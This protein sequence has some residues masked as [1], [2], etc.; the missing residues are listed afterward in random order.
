MAAFTSLALINELCADFVP[1]PPCQLALARPALR[2]EDGE[3]AGNVEMFGDDLYTTRRNV[4]DGAVTRQRTRPELDFGEAPAYAAFALAS[5]CK[6]LIL[7]PPGLQ[8]TCYFCR[9]TEELLEFA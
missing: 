7:T 5:I 8:A 4:G 2:H 6:H 9:F 3:F 1:E